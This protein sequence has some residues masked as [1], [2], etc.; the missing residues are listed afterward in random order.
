MADCTLPHIDSLISTWRQQIDSLSQRIIDFNDRPTYR[1]L[2]R[3]LNDIDRPLQGQTAHQAQHL[4]GIS[5]DLFA[6]FERLTHWFNDAKAQYDKLPRRPNPIALQQIATVLT[7]TPIHLPTPNGQSH[8]LR[9][10]VLLEQLLTQLNQ[11]EASL[12]SLDCA[13]LETERAIQ[14]L[15]RTYQQ[16]QAQAQQL[17]PSSLATLQPLQQ[18]LDQWRD[19]CHCDPIGSREQLSQISPMLQD[20]Q[21][22]LD[23]L[24]Q[25]RQR[26]DQALAQGQ[27]SL[28]QL[29]TVHQQT[30]VLHREAQAKVQ[31]SQPLTAP[32]PIDHLQNLAQWL[33][34]LTAKY[35]AGSNPGDLNTIDLNAIELGLSRWQQQHNQ[36]HHHLQQTLSDCEQAIGQ[37]QELRGR[38]SA[39]QAKAQARGLVEDS[40]LITLASEAQRLLYQRPTP[41][42]TATDL[43]RQYER[44]LNTA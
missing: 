23:R 20:L 15:D 12:A 40:R 29:R 5:Y 42:A 17:P 41:L 3:A 32:I 37:R 35:Q 7:Q 25:Q 22:Q 38:L 14:S 2:S 21:T 16:L 31:P 4:L 39:L 18:Q 19:R 34:R 24:Q 26:I 27:P 6:N 10:E 11:A 1:K 33:D 44:N 28:L 36:I 13:W 30:L 9:A 8:I 43:L